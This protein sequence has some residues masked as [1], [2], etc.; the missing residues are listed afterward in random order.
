MK[1]INLILANNFKDMN[2]AVISKIDA[3]DLTKTNLVIVPDRFSLLAEKAVFRVLKI[4]AYFNIE[5]MG[6]SDLANLVFKKVGFEAEFVTK[7]ES[8]ILLR[9]ALKNLKNK[10]EFFRGK[11][12]V[13]LVDMVYNSM[14]I[15]KTNQLTP[16]KISENNE[17]FGKALSQKMNDLAKIMA[18]YDRLLADRFDSSKVL[19]K[20]AENVQNVDFSTT[21]LFYVGFD[22]FTKQSFELIK[23]LAQS[24]NSLTVG[25]V[26]GGGQKNAFIYES[27]VY[28]KILEFAKTSDLEIEVEK[29]AENLTPNQVFLKN[30]LFSLNPDVK[31]SDFV[32]V[33]EA[34]NIESEIYA[35]AKKIKALLVFD[36][37]RFNQI[38]VAFGDLEKYAD[39]T[40]KIFDEFGFTYFVDKEQNF[41]Q[42]ETVK[43]LC[44]VLK[45]LTGDS[46][47]N[48]LREI[49]ASPFCEMDEN[50]KITVFDHLEK[51]DIRN[52]ILLFETKNQTVEDALKNIKNKFLQIINEN[53]IKNHEKT[54]KNIFFYTNLLKNIISVFSLKEINEKL[55][56]EFQEK[57]FEK[58]E[59]I[60]MQIFDKLEKVFASFE[61]VF[62]VEEVEISEFYEIFTNYL[63]EQKIST[64]PLTTD[65]I[66][67]G[68]A[69]SSFFDECDFLFVASA[70]QNSLP[71]YI[72]DTAI[73]SDDVI[74]KLDGKMQISPTVRMINRRNK[75]KVFDLLLKA[76]KRLFLTYHIADVE[77]KKLFASTFVKDVQKM[78]DASKTVLQNIDNLMFAPQEN[79]VNFDKFLENLG[80]K[81]IAESK[82]LKFKNFT[83]FA[84]SEE[85]GLLQ[86][87]G[88]KNFASNH[89]VRDAKIQ[90]LDKLYFKNDKT[91]VSQ[92]EKFY[93]CPFK[94]FSMYGLKLFEK[95]RA[96]VNPND[97]GNFLHKVAEDFLNPK[98][99]YLQQI[100]Q[101]KN[102]LIKIVEKIVKNIEKTAFFDKFLLKSN[103]LSYQIVKKESF[104]LCSYLFEMSQKTNFKTSFV[105]VYFGSENYP[106]LDI[107]VCGKTF[108]LV[109]V[110]DRVDI[111]D[112][113]FVVFDYKTGKAGNASSTELYYGDKIQI[114]VYAK[115]LQNLLKKRAMGIFYFPIS[116]DFGDTEKNRYALMG[117]NVYYENFLKNFDKTLNDDNKSSTI[118]SCSLNKDGGFKKSPN[119]LAEDCVDDMLKYAVKMVQSAIAEILDDVHMPSPREKACKSCPYVSLCQKSN[120]TN[121]RKNI[122]N[123]TK[124]FDSFLSEINAK[125][126][127]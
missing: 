82:L 51:Y 49:I 66:F 21:N 91:K 84:P 35:I 10:L 89:F 31:K 36:G 54:Q 5:V 124:D 117:K 85:L 40:Q 1:K 6:I 12:T 27:D 105:E 2:N 62:E 45:T 83:T 43:F 77:G 71:R 28:D 108:K 119:M 97:V 111:L 98:N 73:I 116:N 95:P 100:L 13:G 96:E 47:V 115:A 64:V 15:L 41:A 69:T 68:D 93:S 16:E 80:T 22:S 39:L 3:K 14:S 120:N 121:E 103:K 52:N 25:A 20:L 127:D 114:F 24:A 58:Q 55:I 118:F 18:E 53:L 8:K 86:N 23:L 38:S 101:N 112:D 113:M 61:K 102:N 44:L 70:T 74:E 126:N 99:N 92:I 26:S 94:H 9:K 76:K 107:D 59:K 63:F 88:A 19:E 81:N 67:V 125:N 109:G 7:E 17:G 46:D 65:G 122:Y 87:Y 78:F 123:L 56:L 79:S 42:T 57:N 32:E 29:Y 11:I 90:N 4:K 104:S 30:N 48:D 50:Q 106:S 60:Y 34:E 37:V 33:W 72:F 110:V 75:F